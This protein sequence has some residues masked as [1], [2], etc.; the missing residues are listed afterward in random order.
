MAPGTRDAEWV[1]RLLSAWI[2]AV[3]D[4]AVAVGRYLVS[5]YAEPHR[6]YHDRQH[7]SE[8][9]AALD[10]L[11]VGG[12]VPPTVVCAAYGHD[13]VYDP[14]ASDNEQRSAALVT[15]VLRWLGRTAAFVDESC[16]WSC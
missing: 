14:T 5:R 2:A 15:T 10:V 13:A 12:D 11:R 9:L 7:L 1:E 6:Q 3:G 8:V 16:V 4:D